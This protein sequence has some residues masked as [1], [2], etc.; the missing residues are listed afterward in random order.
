MHK[1][2]NNIIIT[3][4]SGWIGRE[5]V[6]FYYNKFGNSILNQIYAISSTQDYIEFDFGKLNVIK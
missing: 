5:V 1:N 3:G 2:I 6:Y 4:S